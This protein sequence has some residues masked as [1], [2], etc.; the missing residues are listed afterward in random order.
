MR[1]S[2]LPRRPGQRGLPVLSHCGI[3]ETRRGSA[4]AAFASS[5][6]KNATA[7][8][9]AAAGAMPMPRS[10][11]SPFPRRRGEP[12]QGAGLMS[13]GCSN[14]TTSCAKRG[15][16]RIGSQ[17]GSS[18][19]RAGETELPLNSG[20]RREY[21]ERGRNCRRGR[22]SRQVNQHRRAAEGIPA[23]RQ[24]FGSAACLANCFILV[25]DP[26]AANQGRGDPRGS[27][28]AAAVTILW[29]AAYVCAASGSLTACF[30][31]ATKSRRGNAIFDVS[32][33]ASSLLFCAMR[34]ALAKSCDHQCRKK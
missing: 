14:C 13:T 32:L 29:T 20:A 6:A 18:F 24:Q 4:A 34:S 22:R 5:R 16:L 33:H 31:H 15:S 12:V 19:R 1:A 26:A 7:A 2:G 17:T 3:V 8:C 9:Q 28:S 11:V 21:V 25:T 30:A 23:R 10:Q 27:C